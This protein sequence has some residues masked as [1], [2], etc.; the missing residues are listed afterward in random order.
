MKKI[1]FILI[2][3]AILMQLKAQQA[4]VTV[5]CSPLSVNF[6][7]PD[8]LSEYFWELGTGNSSLQNPT[9]LYVN[10]GIV[11]VRLF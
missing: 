5:G 11:V 6:T 10:T 8:T 1:F 2:F 9:A 7:A 3:A 4:D